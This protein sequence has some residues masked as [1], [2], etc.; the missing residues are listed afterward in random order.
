MSHTIL[1]LPFLVAFV[2]FAFR[3]YARENAASMAN[4]S[5]ILALGTVLAA[6]LYLVLGVLEQPA[7]LRPPR[8]RPD[9]PRAAWGVDRAHVRHLIMTPG[10]PAMPHPARNAY[11]R[12]RRDQK[13]GCARL[14]CDTCGVA[15]GGGR[16]ALIRCPPISRV[17]IRA[18]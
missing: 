16:A 4:P 1:L 2:I 10:G 18:C 13:P 3:F 17:A 15:E 14:P 11:L 7:A 8:L 12:S 9:R 5:F 6:M